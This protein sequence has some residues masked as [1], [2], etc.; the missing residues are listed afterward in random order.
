MCAGEYVCVNP[1][2]DAVADDN[3]WRLWT[4]SFEGGGEYHKKNIYHGLIKAWWLI[5]WFVN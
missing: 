4:S 2:I 5:H 3:I 1:A